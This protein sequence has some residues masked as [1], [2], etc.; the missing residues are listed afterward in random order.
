VAGH[1][2]VASIDASFGLGEALV[3]GLVTPDLYK[4]DRRTDEVLLAQPGN[5]EL[6]I[7]P[8]P[9]GGTRREALPEAERLA[10]VL[11]DDQVRAFARMAD[12]IEAAFGQAPQDIEWCIA[13]GELWIVQARPITSLFPIPQPQG[14]RLRVVLTFGHLHK[15][16]R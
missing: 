6:A 8:V 7:R 9:G 14:Y 5:K 12:R 4:V 11:N 2:H 1:R 15:H 16:P 10:R 13:R 3:S